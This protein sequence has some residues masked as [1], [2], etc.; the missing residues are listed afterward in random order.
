MHRTVADDIE[1][2]V[3]GQHALLLALE[4]ELENGGEKMAGVNELVQ[5]VVVDRNGGGLF[6]AAVNNAWNAAFATY[7]AGGPCLS[8]YAPRPR[9]A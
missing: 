8:R 7:G 5:L 1:L 9:A 6:A 4:V 2:V 3:A